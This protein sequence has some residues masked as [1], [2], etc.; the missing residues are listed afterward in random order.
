M[1]ESVPGTN[2]YL[3]M[4]VKFLVQVNNGSAF[5]GIWAHNWQIRSQARYPL[6][7]AASINQIINQSINISVINQSINI[8]INQ[9]I[10]TIV[11]TE[12]SFDGIRTHNWQIT[13]QRQR[14]YPLCLTSPRMS[15]IMM[16]SECTFK[17]V[18][19]YDWGTD[20]MI[21]GLPGSNFIIL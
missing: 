20:N 14:G 13:S 1:F 12:S 9:S 7:H 17:V 15:Y 21:H 19:M 3:A 5:D 16:V 6:C 4:R 2:Q 10:K 11:V 18:V 8:S